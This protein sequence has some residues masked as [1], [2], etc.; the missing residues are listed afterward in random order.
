[1]FFEIFFISVVSYLFSYLQ[2]PPPVI[3][4]TFVKFK[5]SNKTTKCV[6]FYSKIR[7]VKKLLKG[8]FYKSY[9]SS[10]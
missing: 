1:M 7:A 6:N 4:Q 5:W 3:K 2:Y 9:S 10:F 8:L